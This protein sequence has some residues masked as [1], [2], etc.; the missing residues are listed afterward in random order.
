M[1]KATETDLAAAGVT[2]RP[3]VVVADAGYWHQAQMDRLINR[4]IGY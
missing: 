4:G 3:Q 1:V 2:A